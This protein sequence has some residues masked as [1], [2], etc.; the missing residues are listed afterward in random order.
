MGEQ[1]KTC[2]SSGHQDQ[3]GQSLFPLASA[4]TSSFQSQS[5]VL[6]LLDSSPE[7]HDVCSSCL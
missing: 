3:D 2:L 5:L 1:G 4:E 7:S 6:L